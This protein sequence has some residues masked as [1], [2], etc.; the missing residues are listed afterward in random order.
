MKNGDQYI[1][2]LIIKHLLE[3]TSEQEKQEL[4]TW[5]ESNADNERQYQELVKVLKVS[6]TYEINHQNIDIDAEW[7]RFERSVESKSKPNDQVK[8]VSFYQQSWLKVAAGIAIIAVLGL[9]IN[10]FLTSDNRLVVVAETETKEVILPDGSIVT[11]NAGSQISYEKEYIEQPLRSVS[12]IGEA[13]FEVES[14]PQQP[15]VVQLDEASVEVVGTSFNIEAHKNMSSINVVVA[16][17]V[18]R[19]ESANYKNSVLLEAGDRGAINKTTNEI[20]KIMNVDVN[21]LSWKTQ[22]IVFEDVSLDRVIQ[23]LNRLYE[24]NIIISAETAVNCKVTVSFDHQSL[25]AILSVLEETL[26]LTY[27]ENGDKIEIISTGC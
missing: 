7:N 23:T 2:E 17:G 11:L 24:A 19:F 6:T 14:N 20:S 9:L 26:D 13:F 25:D 8:E 16:S 21:Y 5:R 18:V 1:E 22:Q 15:F 3:E 12:L 27:I 10:Q 4:Q